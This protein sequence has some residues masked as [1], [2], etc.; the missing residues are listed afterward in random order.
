M[1]MYVMIFFAFVLDMLG[2]D[3]L[4]SSNINKEE[5]KK[6]NRYEEEQKKSVWWSE[7]M[8]RKHKTFG[9]WFL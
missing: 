4:K 2:L 3:D 1:Y 7:N 6:E 9:Y 5:R 8:K